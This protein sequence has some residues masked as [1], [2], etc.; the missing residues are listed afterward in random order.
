M[1]MGPS[2]ARW[3]VWACRLVAGS[4]LLLLLLLVSDSNPCGG[5]D[6]YLHRVPASRRRR[7][8][9]K[10]QL[11]GSKIWSRVPRDSD[12]RKTMLARASSIYKRQTPPLV[13]EGAP[14]KQD[15]NCQRIINIWTPRHT[16]WLTVSRNVTLTLSLWL[17]LSWVCNRRWWRGD[18]NEVVG[19]CNRIWL[20]VPE[21]T[22]ERWRRNRESSVESWKVL[23]WREVFMCAVVQWYLECSVTLRLL[24]I[25]VLK[26]VA[27]KWIVW[28]L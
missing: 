27:R 8:I 10:S 23:Q 6:E 7:R 16:D 22:V 18:G 3:Q 17:W 20:K 21:L 28:R 19:S 2:G 4:K 11:W 25:T 5:G 14:Q 26:S 13:R 15:R 1:A 12:R 24:T 9:G